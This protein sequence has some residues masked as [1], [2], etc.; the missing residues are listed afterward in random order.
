MKRAREAAASKSSPGAES[1]KGS[2]CEAPAAK[3]KTDGDTENS[4]SQLSEGT[5]SF[6]RVLQLLGGP[7]LIPSE[8]ILRSTAADLAE[9]EHQRGVE[10]F[11]SAD[12]KV[13]YEDE[14]ECPRSFGI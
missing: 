9:T 1:S 4:S 12:C 5:D 13:V 6:A 14:E 3:R 10:A 2:P 7:G 11:K 8:R